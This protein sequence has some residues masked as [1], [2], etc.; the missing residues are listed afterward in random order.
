MNYNDLYKHY[1][2]EEKAKLCDQM[3]EKLGM[4]YELYSERRTDVCE[5]ITHIVDPD[6][7]RPKA[8]SRFVIA[9]IDLDMSK[10]IHV[11]YDT[12]TTEIFWKWRR[13]LVNN[14]EESQLR[15]ADHL[16]YDNDI[17]TPSTFEELQERYGRSNP[18]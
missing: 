14:I 3:L 18:S 16:F 7:H 17:N 15:R 6:T 1:T 2:V 12:L 11:E 10:S 8:E 13:D 5:F 4:M 9:W